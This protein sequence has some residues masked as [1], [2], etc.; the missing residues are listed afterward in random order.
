M[1]GEAP[2]IEEVRAG[3]LFS[4]HSVQDR[5]TAPVSPLPPISHNDQNVSRH[6]TCPLEGRTTPAENCVCVAHMCMCSQVV[7]KVVMEKKRLG[8]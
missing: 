6:C 8:Q 1:T 5:V 7:M 2:G 4:T 3:M